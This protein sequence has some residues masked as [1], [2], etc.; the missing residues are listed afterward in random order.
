[1]QKKKNHQYQKNPLLI[2]HMQDINI[3]IILTTLTIL[4]KTLI[5]QHII[6]Y[7]SIQVISSIKSNWNQDRIMEFQTNSQVIT[8]SLIITSMEMEFK[9]EI[10]TFQM[11]TVMQIYHTVLI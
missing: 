11:V 7:L 4:L 5:K 3:N 1:M 8:G 9:V 6:H 2:Y 10:L